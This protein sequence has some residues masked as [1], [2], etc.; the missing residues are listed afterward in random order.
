[1]SAKEID[2]ALSVQLKRN[3]RKISRS[4]RRL[5]NRIVGLVASIETNRDGSIVGPSR[6]LAQSKVILKD[7]RKAFAEIYGHEV[8]SILA[9]RAIDNVVLAHYGVE[10]YT[11]VTKNTLLSMAS[12]DRAY[13]SS[14]SSQT[15]DKLQETFIDHVIN[16]KS[17]DE[18]INNIRGI[19]SGSVDRAGR[20]FA[21]HAKT[22]AQDSLMN[23]YSVANIGVAKDAGVDKFKYYGSVIT[24]T[25][26]WCSG[27]V[28]KTYTLK[29]IQAFDGQ[30]WAGKKPGSTMINRGGYNCRHRW[31]GIIDD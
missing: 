14:L 18:L 28:G 9:P 16:G 27:H 29:Q 25:R 31:V 26:P 19:V 3:E 4:I 30:G 6:S 12:L 2:K 7:S 11:G 10:K 23:Y 22:L 5:E 1:M 17:K 8:E 13:S 24:T 15:M 20:S 21:S